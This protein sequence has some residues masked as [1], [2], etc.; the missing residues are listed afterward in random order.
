MRSSTVWKA[1]QDISEAKHENTLGSTTVYRS[2]TCTSDDH[3]IGACPQKVPVAGLPGP[4][5]SPAFK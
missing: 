4:P 2:V 5:S 3:V 1:K